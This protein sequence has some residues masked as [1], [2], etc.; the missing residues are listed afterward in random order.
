VTFG[1][2]VAFGIVPLLSYVVSLMPGFTMSADTQFWAACVLT[3]ITLF[4]L[5][6]L[7]VRRVILRPLKFII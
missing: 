7:K 2:F 1:S 5:G 6:L 3:V 4:I